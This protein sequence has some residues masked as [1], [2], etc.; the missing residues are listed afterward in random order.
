[1]PDR[2][3]RAIGLA[4]LRRGRGQPAGKHRRAGMLIQDQEPIQALQR[5]AG[6]SALSGFVLCDVNDEEIRTAN[7]EFPGAVFSGFWGGRFPDREQDVGIVRF[8][9]FEWRGIKSILETAPRR[10][11]SQLAGS[12]T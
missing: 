6:A 7:A 3:A 1:M 12:Q 11:R 2:V 8:D 5:L 10:S 4:A 9:E